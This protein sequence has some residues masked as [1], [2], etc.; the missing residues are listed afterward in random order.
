MTIIAHGKKWRWTLAC[1]ASWLAGWQPLPA[2]PVVTDS[3]LMLGHEV[4]FLETAADTLTLEQVLAL[5]E[6]A[7]QRRPKPGFFFGLQDKGFWLRFS[8]QAREGA[9]L[10]FEMAN[11]YIEEFQFFAITE[12]GILQA[13]TLGADFPFGNRFYPHRNWQIPVILPPAD[14]VLCLLHIPACRSPLQF[15]LYLWKHEARLEQQFLES[16]ILTAFFLILLVYLLLIFLVNWVARFHSLWYYFAYVA[17]GALLLFSDLGLSY[18]YL[19]PERPHLHQ[20][21]NLLVS[22][23]YLLAGLQFVRVYFGAARLF[24][25]LNRMMIISMGIAAAFIPFAIGLPYAP[26]RFS[27]LLHL[28]HYLVFMVGFIST[29]GV[30]IMSIVKR[31]RILAGWFLFGFGLHGLGIALAL[32]QYVGWFPLISSTRWLYNWGVPLTFYPQMMMMAGTLIEVPVLFYVAFH[33]FRSLYEDAQKQAVSRENNLNKLV[34]SIEAER[35]RLG[36]DLHDS[37]GVQLAAIKMKL[38]VLQE[39][40]DSSQSRELEQV[41]RDLSHAHREMRAISHDLMP[42]SLGLQGLA[43]AVENL[44]QRMQS[45]QP[46]LKTHFFNNAPLEKLTP[47]ARLHL[48]RILSELITNAVKHAAARELSVQLTRYDGSI[49]ASVEDDGRGFDPAALHTKGI[50]L[51]NVEYRA[52]ALGGRF[53]LDARPGR[54]TFASVE[55]PVEKVMGG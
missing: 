26:L 31:Q 10:I 13:D 27:H 49:Q 20:A 55:V 30:F 24:P 47:R 25:I 50:G 52:K 46:G 15:D 2:T 7:F 9:N 36:Q 14:S 32:L 6:G 42:P 43:A 22:N 44:L 40:A 37:L 41:I 21:S 23:L 34:M 45:L 53:E 17:L 33:R 38:S 4:Q 19:W 29:L 8:L 39:K 28:L 16:A 11:P 5:P 1:L 12:N 54:G 18:R 48:Y 3:F 35:Q 51:S